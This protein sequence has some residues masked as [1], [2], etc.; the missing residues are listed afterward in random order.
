MCGVILDTACAATQTEDSE[1][2]DVLSFVTTLEMIYHN[3][4]R[5]GGFGAAGSGRLATAKTPCSHV[6]QELPLPN[7]LP[8]LCYAYAQSRVKA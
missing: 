8:A 3:V 7:R 1:A 2:F 5:W 6:V 4:T